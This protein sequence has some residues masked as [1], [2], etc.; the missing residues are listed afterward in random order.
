[1]PGEVIVASYFHIREMF[2]GPLKKK[3]LCP[4]IF[5][6]KASGDP[7]FRLRCY[8]SYRGSLGD[9]IRKREPYWALD[10]NLEGFRAKPT[11]LPKKGSAYGITAGTFIAL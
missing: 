10:K 2:S 7:N 5:K 8:F 9:E 11:A 1:M 6:P 3:S 4:Q